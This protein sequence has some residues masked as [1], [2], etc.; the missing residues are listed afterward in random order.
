M[1]ATVAPL[2]FVPMALERSGRPQLF[3]MV[4]RAADRYERPM[5]PASA[6]IERVRRSKSTPRP[7]GLAAE[8]RSCAAESTRS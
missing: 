8:P 4:T 5:L 3:R 2:G 1:T 6:S 7:G